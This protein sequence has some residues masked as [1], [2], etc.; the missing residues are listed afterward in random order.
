MLKQLWEKY[1]HGWVFLYAFIY[2]PWFIYLE[3]NVTTEYHLIHTALDDKIPFIEYFII[4]Y[5]LWFAFIAV[6]FGYF[7]LFAEK[8]EFY[9]LIIM[10]FTG[11]TVF[12][13]ISTVYPNGLNLR[14]DTF[15]RDNLFVDMVKNLYRA[16]T[17]TNVL[18]SI[19]VYNSLGAYI[20]I[21]HCRKLKQYRWVQVSSLIL[22]VSIILSTMFL[23]QHSVID[24]FAAFAMAGIM[25]IAVYGT[26]KV[27]NSGMIQ[28]KRRCRS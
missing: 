12:L 10:M 16:D 28:Y 23:K 22:T 19:H 11:M 9:R 14:P 25:Y 15:V 8:S 18:P 4:P 26:E 1:K 21:S 2:M 17:P 20:A 3:Q 24:V 6:T 13:I 5:T 7:F 27:Q